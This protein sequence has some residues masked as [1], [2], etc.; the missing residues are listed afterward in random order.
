MSGILSV[1]LVV[2]GCG[3]L[4]NTEFDDLS[5]TSAPI[6]D[7]SLDDIS[8]AER[9][10]ITFFDAL[11]R[12]DFKVAAHYHWTPN[13]LIYLYP[14]IDREDAEALLI[15]ACGDRSGCQFYCWKIKDVVD[16]IRVSSNRFVFVV[17]FEDEEGN[18]LTGG[19]NVTPRV[20]DPPGCRHSEY[21]YTV[22]KD[23]GDFYVDGIPVFS[24]CW[25]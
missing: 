7:P 17:R 22:I 12:G 18:L 5:Q 2:N 24:G 23:E 19:D 9:V 3:T 4:F 25:P 16:R 21:A 1:L 13:A 20:C 10:L 8:R 14:D 6:N 11:S 15:E